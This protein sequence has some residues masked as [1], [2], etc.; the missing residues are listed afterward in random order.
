MNLLKHQIIPEGDWWD[1]WD[2]NGDRASGKTVGAVNFANT[3]LTKGLP[4]L[5]LTSNLRM[6][7]YLIEKFGDVGDVTYSAPNRTLKHKSGGSILFVNSTSPSTLHMLRG[8]NF[9]AIIWDDVDVTTTDKLLA[10]DIL[11][12][13]N[14]GLRIGDNP[15]TLFTGSDTIPEWLVSHMVEKNVAYTHAKVQ[16]N[17]KN[18]APS[19]VASFIK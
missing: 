10:S 4:V 1:I 12:M 8:Q 7:D 18:L 15:R 2:L 6:T 19:F 17:L 11:Q 14:F 13:A 3:Y 16:E 9:A 5:W